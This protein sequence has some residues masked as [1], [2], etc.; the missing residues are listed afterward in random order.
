MSYK[1]KKAMDWVELTDEFNNVL[2]KIFNTNENFFITGK[3]GTGKST[4]LQYLYNTTDKKCVLLAPTG[5]ASLNIGGQTMHSFFQLD[6]GVLQASNYDNK[7]IPDVQNVDTIIID[8]IS[9]V[10]A[11]ILDSIDHIL[12]NTM[13]S[14]LPFGGK[15][16]I[17]F[18]DPYQLYIA[19]HLLFLWN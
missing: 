8:E 15:Q 5:R 12:K 19:S 16:V 18:G 13:R 3:A 2:Y 7:F 11:D 4:L 1:T 9:M 14:N 6:W 17:F 10:R